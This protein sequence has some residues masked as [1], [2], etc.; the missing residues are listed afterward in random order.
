M[1]RVRRRRTHFETGI[2]RT[3][4]ECR[5]YVRV[6]G[7]LYTKRFDPETATLTEMRD[8]RA[9]K[10]VE[11]LAAHQKRAEPAQGTFGSDVTTYLATVKA[12]PTYAEREFHMQQWLD[13]LGAHRTTAS[14][15]GA[16]IRAVLQT[17]RLRPLAESSCNHRR[18]ALMHFFT[19][20]NGRSG[21]NPVRDVPKFREPDP[22]PRGVDFAIL[23]RIFAKMPESKT[24]ARALVLATT[25]LP[26]STLM[27]LTED[28]V[29]YK[30]KTVTV[31]RRRKGKGTKLR[32]L[33]LS[34]D[35]VRAFKLLTRYDG[36]GEFSRDSLRHSLHRACKAAGVPTMRGYDLRHSFGTAAY[37]ASGDIRAVQ[38]L[39]D[40]SDAKLTE[41]YTLGAVEHRTRAAVKS[42]RK[43]TGPV[44]SKRK[45]A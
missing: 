18:T 1:R 15:T 23:K 31:P 5:A 10:R 4:S 6:K 44:A 9:A 11:V 24:K 13:M 28:A 14:I 29:N 40:H 21:Y 8:W 2:V 42:L 41:R 35:A 38:A 3:K 30:A 45:S 34:T 16:D 32:V 37:K 22:E 7:T 39:L 19:V 17:W 12:M 25:G 20:L 33:P 36:W 26:P 27:R 43:V